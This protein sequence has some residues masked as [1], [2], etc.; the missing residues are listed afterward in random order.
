[1]GT[2]LLGLVLAAAAATA[3]VETTSVT[4]DLNT[5]VVHAVLDAGVQHQ[6]I[7]VQTTTGAIAL[8][9]QVTG[10]VVTIATPDG[11]TLTA[12]ERRDTTAVRAS[13]RSPAVTTIYDLDVGGAGLIPGG[14]YQLRVVAPDGRT[15]TGRT[16]IPHA[17]P[18]TVAA[19]TRTID[20]DRDTVSLQWSR[21][22]GARSYQVF[23]RS[24]AGSY[25]LFVADTSV[26]LPGTLQVL[27]NGEDVFERRLTHQLAVVAVDENYFDY[28]RHSTDDVTATGLVMHLDGGIG[29]FG[30]VVT[31][32]TR[33]IVVQ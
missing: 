18:S 11:R 22:A 31:V 26:V 29:V 8:Q 24:I 17:V 16:T 27:E 3:C 23:V 9:R 6:I 1:M 4:P 2:R 10:A 32:A 14:T 25:G 30:S 21:V 12:V 7:V 28:Y 20:R 5:L 33:T 13:F 19:P 15:V